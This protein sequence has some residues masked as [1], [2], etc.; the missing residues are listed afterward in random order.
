MAIVDSIS[1]DF[2]FCKAR[3]TLQ[4]NENQEL[5]SCEIYLAIIEST[6]KHKDAE[7]K[8]TCYCQKNTKLERQSSNEKHGKSANNNAISSAGL[9]GIENTKCIAIVKGGE[10]SYM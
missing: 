6:A 9:L 4:I 1:F 8:G 7:V 10:T 3:P 2:C 5:I